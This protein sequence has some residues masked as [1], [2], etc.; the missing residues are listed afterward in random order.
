MKVNKLTESFCPDR[1]EV[2]NEEL[3]VE[4]PIDWIKD[5]LSKKPIDQKE[6]DRRAKEKADKKIQKRKE[7]QDPQF[8]AKDFHGQNAKSTFYVDNNYDKPMTQDEWRAW[9]DKQQAKIDNM[10]AEDDASIEKRDKAQQKLDA[11]R[12]NAIVVNQHGRYMRRGAEPLEAK[13]ITFVPGENDRIANGF[14]MEPYKYKKS[15]S[16]KQ[17]TGKNSDTPSKQDISKFMTICETTGMTIIDA[18]GKTLNSS[19]IRKIKLNELKNYKVKLGNVGVP[20]PDWI[21]KAKAKKLI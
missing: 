7:K 21:A 9:L 1:L 18:D 19:D 17:K 11:Q 4:G 14:F 8:I 20:I 16:V 3:L 2:L 12:Y 10:P 6:A 13:V 5:K 15:G